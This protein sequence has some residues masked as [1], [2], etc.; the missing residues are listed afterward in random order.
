VTVPDPLSLI[1]TSLQVDREKIM[2]EKES[3][4]ETVVDA[5]HQVLS[6][7]IDMFPGKKLAVP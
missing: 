4:T 2:I 7:L 6:T 1:A 5:H 3:A